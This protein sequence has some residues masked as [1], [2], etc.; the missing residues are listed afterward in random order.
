MTTLC[1]TPTLIFHQK[2]G[3]ENAFKIS[4]NCL[5]QKINRRAMSEQ[6]NGTIE[7]RTVNILAINNN[8]SPK[9]PQSDMFHK[10]KSC[11]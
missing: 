6:V 10:V 3:Y 4:I 8:L 2:L 9:D 5:Q 11:C 7:M 1:T